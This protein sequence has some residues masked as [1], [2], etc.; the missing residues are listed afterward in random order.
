MLEDKIENFKEEIINN[1]CNLIKIP[2]VNNEK[3]ENISKNKPF[4][5]AINNALEY[6]L[7]LGEKLG[8]RTKNVDGYCGYI[9]FGEGKELVGIIGHLDVVPIGDGW[10]YNPFEAKINDGKI[11]GRGAIDDKGPVIASLYAMKAVKDTFKVNKRVRLILGTNEESEWKCINYYKEHEEWPTIGFSPDADFPCIYAEKGI[12]TIYF[13]S[14]YNEENE[15]IKIKNIDCKDNAIN[16]VPKYCKVELEINK[17]NTEE[18]VKIIEK[19]KNEKNFDINI[20]VETKRK[21]IIETNGISAHAAH[22]DLGVNAISI[23]INVLEYI[24]KKFGVKNDLINFFSEKIGMEYNGK[25][26]GIDVIDETGSLTLNVGDF[27]LEK[28][29]LKIGL[30]LRIPVKTSFDYIENKLKEE[31]LKYKNIEMKVKAKQEPLFVNKKS[32]LVE[33]LCGIFNEI[34]G[35]NDVPLAIG[36]GTYARAFENVISFGANMPGNKDMCHQVDEYIK[37]EDLILASKIYA[38]AIY[39]LSK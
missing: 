23:M 39:E 14:K 34:T 19:L 25:K 7:N 22:P 13:E 31:S 33:T 10:T 24:L 26:I 30:N 2:S 11:Y 15:Y 8:F 37:I 18:I 1:T 32:Y 29:I 6:T 21:L 20:N 35:R 17:I 4:G 28:D 3:K 36:G 27:K 38:K 9:E 5:E 12:E 16:V